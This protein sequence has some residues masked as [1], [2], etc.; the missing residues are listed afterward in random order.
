MNL[1]LTIILLIL[2]IL[3]GGK[4]GIK[5]FISL[6]LN[7]ILLIVTFYFIALGMNSIVVA[8]IGCAIISTIVLF[9]VNG[10]NLKTKSSM[11]SIIIVLIILALGIFVITKISRIAGFGYE[12]LEEINMFSYDIKLDMTNVSIAL[13]LIGLIGAT[14]DSS[15]AISSALF[16]VYENNK[17]LTKRELYLSGLTIGKDI[18]GTTTNTLLFAFLGEFM[19]LLIWF[20]RCKYNFTDIINAKVFCAEFI[21]IMFSGIGCIL[22]IPITSFVTSQAIKNK[23][24]SSN[25]K[26]DK[27]C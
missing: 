1:I 27:L 19:T 16:E 11:I 10:I 8:L 20:Q 6:V 9:F 15:I 24:I 26:I 2:M 23:Y 7:F 25:I 18:L 12:S 5:S 13:I 22:V 17:N 14:I 4:R 21:K 3:V